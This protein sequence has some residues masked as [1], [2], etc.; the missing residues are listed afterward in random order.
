MEKWLTLATHMKQK[1]GRKLYRVP[2]TCGFTCPNR[3]GI[4]DNRGCIF[5]SRSGAGEFA[6]TYYGQPL[7]EEDLIYNHQHVGVGNY[8]AY[9]QAFTN[10]YGPIE[11]LQHLFTSALNDPLFAGIAIATRPDC[12]GSDVLE[13]FATLKKQYSDKIFIVELGLQTIN[14]DTATWMRRG[15]ALDVFDDAVQSLHQLDIEIV[16]HIILGLSNETIDD[17]IKTIQHL[18]T[19]PIQGIK[20]QSLQ[21]LRNTDLGDIYLENPNI[22][23]VLEKDEYVSYVAE[24]LAW[25]RKDIVVHRLTGDGDKRILIAPLWAMEKGQV[26]NAIRHYMAIHQLTQGCRLETKQ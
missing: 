20:I 12:L 5:C 8:I 2:L 18:N 25:L 22:F 19:L 16:V 21:Y 7:K 1:Y 9:F 13:L 3:D 6:I 26:I 23:H 11:K 4:I 14:E 17:Y 15:Y 24:C 10:T